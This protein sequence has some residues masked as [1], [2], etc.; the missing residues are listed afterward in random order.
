MGAMIIGNLG[1]I[2][3]DYI[4][5]F[6]FHMGIFGAVFNSFQLVKIGIL[7]NMVAA[8][9]FLGFPSLIAQLSCSLTYGK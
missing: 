1:N 2:V 5:I 4:F 7:M 6:P 3:L 8:E 9:L